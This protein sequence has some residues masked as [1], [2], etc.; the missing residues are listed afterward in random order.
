MTFDYSNLNGQVVAKYGTQLRFAEAMELSERSLSLKLNNKVQ[1]KQ[2]EIAKAAKLLG[3]KTADIPKYF[4]KLK[5][6]RI[7]REV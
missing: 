6:Q 2:A 1:W 7:E 4:F 5:V 3:I